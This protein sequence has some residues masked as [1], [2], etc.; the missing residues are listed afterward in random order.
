VLGGG[1]EARAGEEGVGEGGDE[2]V[3]APRPRLPAAGALD[4]ELF[5]LA[6]DGGVRDRR[7]RLVALAVGRGVA[8]PGPGRG[9]EEGDE[10][11]QAVRPRRVHGVARVEGG[12]QAAV[13]GEHG[14]DATTGMLLQTPPGARPSIRVG[15]DRPGSYRARS[16]RDGLGARG[17]VRWK[18]LR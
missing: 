1:E 2:V 18:R 15:H 10:E 16:R 14:Q 9:G 6:D 12:R 11:K 17:V 3:L 5:R 8:R 7:H 13:Y 4:A